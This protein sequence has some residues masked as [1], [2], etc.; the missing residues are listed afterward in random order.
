M[1]DSQLGRSCRDFEAEAGG[2]QPEEFV[3]ARTGQI[4]ERP[5]AADLPELTLEDFEQQR[6]A[7]ARFA[8]Q[9]AEPVPLVD[10]KVQACQR[11]VLRGAL[12]EQPRV[13]MALERRAAQAPIGE[14][15]RPLRRGGR[16]CGVGGQFRILVIFG[17]IA[18]KA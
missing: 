2:Q 15:D 10:Q 16:R 17:R 6:L 4:D 13:E 3:L 1:R 9:Q 14:I 8:E 12:M 5:F 11:L 7:S 18:P